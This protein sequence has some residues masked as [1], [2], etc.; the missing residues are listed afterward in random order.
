MGIASAVGLYFVGAVS[1][2]TTVGILKYARVPKEEERE[3][4]CKPKPLVEV[5]QEAKPQ[6]K[7]SRDNLNPPK[8]IA[9]I[10]GLFGK[11]D[12]DVESEYSPQEQAFVD[13]FDSYA[14]DAHPIII[15]EVIDPRFEKYLRSRLAED[16]VQTESNI[17]IEEEQE[18]K[19]HGSSNT[20]DGKGPSI[21][22]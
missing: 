20:T 15:K 13:S 11:I 14:R 5:D 21:G 10:S 19:A 8:K 4:P 6:E 17:L 3:Y 12:N 1:T 9:P 2:F 16:Q 22:S 7:A 18:V